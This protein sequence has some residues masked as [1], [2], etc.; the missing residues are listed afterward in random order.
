[1]SN[2]A[3]YRSASSSSEP[4]RPVR[5]LVT[6]LILALLSLLVLA[7]HNMWWTFS[8]MTSDLD[9][10]GVSARVPLE[11]I[12]ETVDAVTVTASILVVALPIVAW[13]LRRSSWWIPVAV[14]V[15][16]IVATGIL[17]RSEVALI[18]SLIP[19]S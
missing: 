3:L 6:S 1:M 14:T 13:N 12:S 2:R 16:A 19:R 11:S 15:L 17:N 8:R 9:T 10:H 7:W 5:E 18:H 4:R